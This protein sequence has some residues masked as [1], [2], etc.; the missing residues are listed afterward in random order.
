M[1]CHSLV[2]DVFQTQGLNGHLDLMLTI[3][4]AGSGLTV[5]SE[6]FSFSFFQFSVF[7]SPSA[8]SV[9]ISFQ[10]VASPSLCVGC[11][12]VQQMCV[13]PLSQGVRC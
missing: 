10:V 12:G 11:W 4:M 6:F 7:V 9:L 3:H 13:V 1:G 2:Q 5:C 8:A